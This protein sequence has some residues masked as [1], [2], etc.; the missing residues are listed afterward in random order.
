MKIDPKNEGYQNLYR[1]PGMFEDRRDLIKFAF[2]VIAG[3]G[4]W[5]MV[6]LLIWWA[7]KG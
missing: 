1:Q 7:V 5:V 3:L 2:P 6:G 4:G